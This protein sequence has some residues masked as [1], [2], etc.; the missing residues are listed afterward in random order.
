MIKIGMCD[1][2]LNSIINLIKISKNTIKNIK[3][4]D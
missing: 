3:I 1:D 2:N 4:E